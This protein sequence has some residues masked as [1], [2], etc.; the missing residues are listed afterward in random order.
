MSM[1]AILQPICACGF[2][3]KVFFMGGGMRNF[4]YSC[5]VP[6]HC[7]DC[8]TIKIRNLFKR[9]KKC[10]VCKGIE[11]LTGEKLDSSECENCQKLLP[12]DLNNKFKCGKCK[13]ELVMYGVNA[14]YFD[15]TNLDFEKMRELEESSHEWSY[16]LD[17]TY[18]LPRD[19]NYCPKC[20]QNNLRFD[21]CGNW[22]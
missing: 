4:T 7:V 19:S 3:F 9:V 18:F 14:G 21:H 13:G 5:E 1:G 8:E 20:K 2:Q 15:D 10:Q 16:M 6:F 12:P 22:D 17:R 11:K